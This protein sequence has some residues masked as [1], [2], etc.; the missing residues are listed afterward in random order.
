MNNPYIYTDP[1]GYFFSGFKR[2]NRSVIRKASKVLGKSLTNFLGKVGSAWCRSWAAVCAA[3]WSY[4]FNRA[5]GVSISGSLKAAAVAGATTHIFTEIGEYYGN[6]S[7]QSVSF[8]KSIG[9][10]GAEGGMSPS[11]SYNLALDNFVNFGGNYLTSGQVAGQI[12]SHAVAGGV[13][14]E[15]SGGKFGHGFFSA[16]V[17]KGFGGA[18]LPGGSHIGGSLVSAVVGGTASVISGGKFS[19]GARTVA[20]QYLFNQANG[21]LRR[22]GRIFNAELQVIGGAASVFAGGAISKSGFGIILGLPLATHGMSNIKEG[23]QIVAYETFGGVANEL[24]WN[25]AP[26]NPARDFWTELTGNP[27]AFYYADSALIVGGIFKTPQVMTHYPYGRPVFHGNTL[28]IQHGS[29]VKLSPMF[30]KATSPLL[31]NDISTI[32]QNTNSLK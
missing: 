2:F 32:Y 21:F 30:G 29:S 3:G 16:G 11:F 20:F 24:G 14:S 25:I 4:E 19:N 17:T 6:L 22:A 13:I 27:S 23:L 15:L 10:T 28:T 7:E 31:F 5:H 26:Q 12:L 1:S 9:E 18:L 8:A